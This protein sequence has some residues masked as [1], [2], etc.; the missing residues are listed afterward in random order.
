MAMHVLLTCNRGLGRTHVDTL[1]CLFLRS[2]IGMNIGLRIWLKI[3]RIRM[4]CWREMVFKHSGRSAGPG[5]ARFKIVEPRSQ[6]PRNCQ[7]YGRFISG[8][9]TSLV[10]AAPPATLNPFGD[11]C[12]SAQ[13]FLPRNKHRPTNVHFSKQHYDCGIFG[14]LHK[15]LRI[16]SINDAMKHFQGDGT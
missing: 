10:R 4:W 6:F 13:I 14:V 8:H 2:F 5:A 7:F 3:V 9:R 1:C 16:S 12:S 15:E 11:R